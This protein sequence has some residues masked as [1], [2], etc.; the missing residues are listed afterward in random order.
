MKNRRF[1]G[2]RFLS[3][4]HFYALF[5]SFLPSYITHSL[6]S[7]SCLVQFDFSTWEIQHDEIDNLVFPSYDFGRCCAN[8]LF[9][10]FLTKSTIISVFKPCSG[11]SYFFE[12][13]DYNYTLENKKH[14]DYYI[15][16]FFFKS[17]ITEM[18]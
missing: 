13:N 3:P 4:S 1:F 5:H 6:Y 8:L 18:F 11:W 2:D 17:K 15:I 14:T 9:Q 10:N 12:N 16:Q 7:D